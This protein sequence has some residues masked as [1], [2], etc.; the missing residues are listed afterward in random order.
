[1][2][3]VVEADKAYFPYM[4]KQEQDGQNFQRLLKLDDSYTP[5]GIYWADL[6]FVERV[7]FVA[8]T[9]AQEACREFALMVSMMQKNPLSPIGW[10]FRNAVLPGA[11]LGLEG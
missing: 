5:E 6:P 2:A 1:M 3:S 7:K 8:R 11:G 9:D 4:R 10:Y